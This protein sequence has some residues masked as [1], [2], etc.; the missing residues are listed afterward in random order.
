MVQ[1]L[2]T[3]IQPT[4][5]Q[6]PLLQSMT[7]LQRTAKSPCTVIKD[8]S[9]WEI[10]FIQNIIS[11]QLTE[12]DLSPVVRSPEANSRLS[13]SCALILPIK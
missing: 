6:L 2:L 7:L 11:N 12:A 8:G 9:E 4:N 10:G 5:P 13:K 1:R 3:N